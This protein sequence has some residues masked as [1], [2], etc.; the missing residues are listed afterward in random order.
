M[1]NYLSLEE[2]AEKLGV[3]T[4]RLVELRSQG[5]V[6]GFRD[7][8]SWKF[9]ENEIDRLAD[10]LADS[11]GG[12]GILVNESDLGTGSSI[13]EG[14]S[15]NIIGGD[16]PV[17]EDGGSDLGIGGEALGVGSDVNLIAAEG[18]GSDVAIVA[19]DA[20]LLGESSGGDLLEIDSAELQLG[21]PAIMHDSAQLDLAIEPNAGSTGPVTDE[22]LREISESHPDVLSPEV[23]QSGSNILAAGSDVLGSDILGA[24]SGVGSK[25]P[26][27]SGSML[28]IGG[29][30]D[31]I[32]LNTESDLSFS[33]LGPDDDSGEE[34]IGSD[35]DSGMDVLGSELEPGELGSQL[36][37]AGA[38]SLELMGDLDEPGESDIASM[39]SRGADVL[40]ELDLLSAEQQGS[41]LITGDSEN[42]LAS[43]GLGS[44]IGADGFKD[45]DLAGLD[46]ALADDDDLVIADDDD[47]LV[48][49]NAGSDISVA[50]DSGINLMSPSDS[51]LSLESEPLDLA[52]SSISA[53]DLGAELS[54]GGGSSGSGGGSGSM[55]DF[56]AD[57]EFQLSPSG[58]GLDADIESGSQ[59]IEVEDSEAIGEAVEFDDAEFGAAEAGFA[60]PDSLG[61]D[62]VFGA[63]P[64]GEA[65]AFDDEEGEA[66]AIDES[67]SPMV[68]GPATFGGY[69]VPFTMLQCVVLMMILMVMSLGGMLMTDLVR[70]MWTYTEPSAPVSSLT[71]SLVG[72]M[73]WGP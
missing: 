36:S 49:S 13:L 69:E 73:N 30:L 47:D 41:G 46:D 31:D 67:A 33:G 14:S 42:L 34:L 3:P 60:D 37:S 5:E 2:A 70:N 68:S 66:V 19:S 35:D 72:V 63:E 45:S 56:Q 48:I 65:L 27:S 40:S 28:D 24:G 11:I 7:G 64:E 58:V 21:D 9:P 54:D 22:E 15:G 44:S 23:Q 50:G 38:S 52:G 71:D 61:G 39:G 25:G 62:D 18:D 8:A 1:A 55:V 26:G 4:D 59:V 51:G 53:L 43:S 6:R 32:K 17:S 20:D 57:E 29:E 10:E 12:S 16:S